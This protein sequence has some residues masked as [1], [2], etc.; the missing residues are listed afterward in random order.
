MERWHHRPIHK[1]KAVGVYMITGSTLHKEHFFKT[2]KDLDLLQE[3]LFQLVDR[4]DLGL[5]AWAIFPN[6]YHL[7]LVTHSKDCH[8]GKFIGHFHSSTA[9]ELNIRHKVPGRKVWFQ[10]WDTQITNRESFLARMHYV[11]TNPEKHGVV[12]NSQD[13]RW[14]SARWFFENETDSYIGLV[15]S[16]KSGKITIQDNYHVQLTE[17]EVYE[18]LAASSE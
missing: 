12:V 1:T 9:R 6:H 7:L 13:Y 15:R 5:R 11:I 17:L 18:G 10:Y 3:T 4:Y 8:L 14:C 2:A 16:F